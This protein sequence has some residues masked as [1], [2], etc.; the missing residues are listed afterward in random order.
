[1][2][3]DFRKINDLQP[4]VR[5]VDSATSGNISLVP[6]PKINEMYAVLHGAKVFTT[7]DL[8]SSYYHINLDEESKAKTVFVTPFGKYEFN[9]V[10][11]GLAQAP[12]Y[13]QQLI[14]MVLQD[15]RDFVM[16]YLDDII[17]FSRTPEEHLKHI[18]I[19]FQKLKAAGLKFKE[20]KC[21]F[22][23]S[24]IHYLGHL[25][26]DKGIQPL[27]E[28][29]DTIRNM[30]RPWT[31]KE[32][33]Q[34]LGLTGYYRKFVPHF[35]EISRPLAKLTAKDMQF[36]WTPQCQFSFEMLKDALM[37]API[38]KYP[39]TEKPYTIFTDASKYGWAGV[40]TQEHTSVING[41]QVTTNHP[42][43]YVSGMFHGS[44]LNW[45][46]IMKEA[47]AIY[48]TVKKSTFYLTGADIML[49]SDH[50]PLNKFLQK[51]TLNLHVNNWAV[52]I[53]SF[54]IKFVHIAGKDNVITDTLSHL[55]DI[56]PDIVLEPELKDY[57]FGS[58]CF[59]TLP[60]ARRLSAAEKLASVDGVDV[61]EISITYDNDENLP[62]S[63]KMPLSNGKFSQL[64]VR[65]EKIK[66]LRVR[67][68]N[69][70]YSDFYKIENDIL[71]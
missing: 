21:D 3:I 65:D 59:E 70:E 9:A 35:S 24:E 25:I 63:I 2:C 11:F 38:L 61:C 5:R 19:I 60:K 55:I 1:M 49:R 64:Q 26:S 43:A 17:I 44:Q 45:A 71:Y 56:D 32:I 67:V 20:S 66:N 23:K 10:P 57:E 69:G 27:P 39:D 48:M 16:V 14:S 7:L 62:N 34:F 46:A 12:A 42:V 33:K 22:F 47:Y 36:E 41:K 13:F 18:E 53:E 6:I 29:L 37:S 30:P 31:P 51:N 40:L 52:E 4:Q 28:K 68:N 50:L 58:Y 54:K 15:C 8:R